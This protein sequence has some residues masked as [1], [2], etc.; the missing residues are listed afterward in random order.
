MVMA[1]GF[2]ISLIVLLIIFVLYIRF[3][4]RE[5]STHISAM[6]TT[7]LLSPGAN[8]FGLRSAGMSQIRGNGILALFF[9]HIYFEMLLPKKELII[10]LSSILDIDVKT[11]FLGKTR[12]RKLLVIT[13][14]DKNGD[15]DQ[16]AWLISNLNEW[17]ELLTP[18]HS[19]IW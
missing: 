13:Y 9:D 16:A 5:I 1:I 8:F 10:P 6:G 18:G 7:R 17:L 19:K 3:R 14:K 11:S 2:I 15:E 4:Y 12:F